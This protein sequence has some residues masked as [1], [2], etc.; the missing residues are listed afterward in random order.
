M[1]AIVTYDSELSVASEASARQAVTL[2]Q[3]EEIDI[4]RG[5]VP[6]KPAERPKVTDQQSW[7]SPVLVDGYG[8]FLAFSK[9]G[10][11][12]PRYLGSRSHVK[13]WFVF[14]S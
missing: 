6:A 14:T 3:D 9:A 11:S 8:V 12:T 13:T 4:S 1:K 2:Q 5:D 10:G 7:S